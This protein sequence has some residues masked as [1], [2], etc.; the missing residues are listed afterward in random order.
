MQRTT[1]GLLR[2]H[3]GVDDPDA[4]VRGRAQ[5][6]IELPFQHAAE[7]RQDAA[8]VR[9]IAERRR[10]RLGDILG[11]IKSQA[12]LGGFE[13]EKNLQRTVPPQAPVSGRADGRA[14][15]VDVEVVESLPRPDGMSTRQ[16]C[17]R[18]V[19]AETG[20]AQERSGGVMR[21]MG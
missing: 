7:A 21:E 2:R 18:H 17:R 11:Q 8:Q 9:L 15:A 19:T 10:Q 1:G 3:V 13:V 20:L 4:A 5:R 16:T 6:R 14:Q 12:D